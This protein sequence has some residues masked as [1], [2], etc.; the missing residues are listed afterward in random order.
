MRLLILGGTTEASQLARA[1]AERP[2]IAATL[3][4]AGRTQSPLAPPI[5]YRVGGFGGIE[6]LRAY[7]RSERIDAVVDATHPFAAQMSLNA[8]AACR[9]EGAPLVVF[10]RPAWVRQPGDV[11]TEVERVEDAVAALGDAPRNVFLTQGRLQ[12]GAFRAAP[13]HLYVVR[14]IDPPEA[15]AALP[16]HRLILARGPFRLEDEL[17][18]LREQAIDI[19]VTKNSGGAATYPKIEAARR[20][21]VKVVMLERPKGGQAPR[22]GDLKEALAWIEAHRPAP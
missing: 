18:L 21:G 10:T 7:L 22:V 5:P 9:L 17:A 12:L 14:A 19:L 2:D 3:S 8:E 1:L 6:G 11:W 15:I 13:Q 16:R 20:L 4:L